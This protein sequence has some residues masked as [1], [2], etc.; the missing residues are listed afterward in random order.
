MREDQESRCESRPLSY[1]YCYL[2]AI[3]PQ[4][5]CLRSENERTQY[6]EKEESG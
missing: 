4:A 3:L 1:S 6:A 5:R 2:S